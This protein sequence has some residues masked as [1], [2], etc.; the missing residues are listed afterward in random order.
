MTIIP[1]LLSIIKRSKGISSPG[2]SSPWPVVLNPHSHH[3]GNT[4]PSKMSVSLLSKIMPK[5]AGLPGECR[6]AHRLASYHKSSTVMGKTISLMIWYW[7]PP[8]SHSDWSKRCHLTAYYANTR[9]WT[10]SAT[11]TLAYFVKNEFF[12]SFYTLLKQQ[13]HYKL[14][15]TLLVFL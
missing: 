9:T 11:V 10:S 15:K 13:S 2:C 1:L 5:A 8:V 12:N 7:N 6:T 3:Q 4:I 14:Q